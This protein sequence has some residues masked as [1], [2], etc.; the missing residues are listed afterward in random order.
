MRSENSLSQLEPQIRASLEQGKIAEFETHGFSMV[1]LLHDGGDFVRLKKSTNKLSLGAVA[2]CK[3]DDN[4]YV[5]HRVIGYKDEGYI[6]KG[7]NCQTCEFCRNDADVIGV[8]VAF[9]R[10]GKVIEADSFKYRLYT[11]FR[12]PFLAFW[13]FFWKIADKINAKRI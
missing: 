10:K 6:L 9:V 3:T 5:L 7:D 13:R 11:K 8:A 12:K 2:F 1:P 4:R